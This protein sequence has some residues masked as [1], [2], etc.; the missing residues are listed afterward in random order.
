MN[1]LI[2]VYS[3][4]SSPV[5]ANVEWHKKSRGTI[6][7]SECRKIN[8][9]LFPQPCDVI[10]ENHPGNTITG[11][12]DYAGVRIF[13]R[14]FIEQIEIYLKNFIL[15]KCFEKNGKLIDD[16]A[17]CY[18]KKC[19]VVR[20]NEN[21]EYRIC[22]ACGSIVQVGWEGRLYVLRSY[23]TNE[24]I[25]QDYFCDMYIEENL[26][27]QINFTFWPD[28]ELRPIEIF[29]EPID[30]RHFPCDPPLINKSIR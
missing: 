28:T 2:A 5:H 3:N 7:C 9:K 12:V 24:K 18:S 10:L 14:K 11:G 8:R 26:A 15:G 27:S 4:H 17:T 25:Y 20:G 16:F 6:L 21:N 22:K 30:G 19:V 29:D 13:H 1:K 23:L